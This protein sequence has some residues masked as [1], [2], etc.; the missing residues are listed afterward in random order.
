MKSIINIKEKQWKQRHWELS[1]YK[2]QQSWWACR[3]NKKN[4]IERQNQL[5]KL[6]IRERDCYNLTEMIK[7]YINNN[8]M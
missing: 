1:L 6:D 4:K 5:L 7:S 8:G 2:D 3:R